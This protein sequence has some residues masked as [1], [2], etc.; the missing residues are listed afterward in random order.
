LL[1]PILLSAEPEFNE[2]LPV[3][4]ILPITVRALVGFVVPM[5]TLE[6]V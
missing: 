5:P 3:A 6:R 4:D 2:I 1:N